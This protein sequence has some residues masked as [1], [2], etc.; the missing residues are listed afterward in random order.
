[1]KYK[2]T[3]LFSAKEVC[4]LSIISAV[5]AFLLISSMVQETRI[6]D[7]ITYVRAGYGFIT[8][9]DFRLDPFNPPFARE[10]VA[11]PAL[12]NPSVMDDP[13]L[14]WP[15][16]VVVVFSIGL[17]WVVYILARKL[18]GTSVAMCAVLLIAVEPNMLTNGH[19][20]TMDLLFTFFYLVSLTVFFFWRH[21]FTKPKL[22]IFASILGLTLSSKISSVIFLLIPLVVLFIVTK[23]KRLELVRFQYWRTHIKQLSLVCVVTLLI[24]WATYFFT[25]EPFLGYRFDPHRPAFSLAQDNPILRIGL[26]VPIPLGSYISTVKQILVFNYTDWYT[27]YSM[28]FGDVRREGFPGYY[29]FP[30]VLIKTTIPFLLLFFAGLVVL[31]KKQKNQ[32][33]LIVIPLVLIFT[34]ILFTKVML[35]TRYVLPVFPLMAIIAAGSVLVHTRS[36]YSKYC[37]IG[38]FLLWHSISSLSFFPYFLTYVNEFGGGKAAGYKAVFDANYDW[39]QG[40]LALREYQQRTDKTLQL[41]Y[42]GDINPS[43]VGLVYERIF[44]INVHDPKPLTPLRF[45]QRHVIAISNTCWYVCGYYQHPLLRDEQPDDI[46]GGSI[47][48]FTK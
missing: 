47:L 17:L 34:G 29:F 23:Q 16:M 24:L 30:L 12:V 22:I 40:L 8:K 35:V 5:T 21:T 1:M 25:F 42:F 10:L 43:E 18:F 48:L 39:G 26:T 31:L 37:V 6:Y 28:L 46:I 33:L 32:V 9:H 45:D 11:L 38:C 15:R 2:L 41:A 27:K 3:A 13:T 44:D 7:E 20:A 36:T 19:Y 14:F 4:F